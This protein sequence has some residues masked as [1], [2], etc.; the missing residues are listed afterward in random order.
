M[1]ISPHIVERILNHVSG[2]L[3]PISLV[4]NKYHFMP[5]MRA[6]IEAWDCKIGTLVAA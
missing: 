6:A 2:S 1:G 5:E 3:S 4:Y